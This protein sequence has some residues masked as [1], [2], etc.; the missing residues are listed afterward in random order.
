MYPYDYVLGRRE[1]QDIIRIDHCPISL[2]VQPAEECTG[3]IPLH[4][5]R[6]FALAG[7]RLLA[8]TTSNG[9][10]LIHPM[11]LQGLFCAIRW[12]C[13][14]KHGAL[15]AQIYLTDPRQKGRNVELGRYMGFGGTQVST[16]S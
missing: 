4:E 1:G 3:A 5:K 7:G 11:V 6:Y 12:Y 15:Q 2:R 14:L 16:V 9:Q 13:Q 8:F 10:P